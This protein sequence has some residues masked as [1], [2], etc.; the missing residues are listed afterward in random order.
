VHE[1]SNLLGR[2]NRPSL[3]VITEGVLPIVRLRLLCDCSYNEPPGKDVNT[4]Y[5]QQY[6]FTHPW[7]DDYMQSYSGVDIWN[8]LSN[9]AFIQL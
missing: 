7:L 4:G 6:E 3:V 8:F 2:Q 1:L 5:R 9:M